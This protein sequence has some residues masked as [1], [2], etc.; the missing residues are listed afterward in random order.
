[1]NDATRRDATRRAAGGDAQAVQ[2]RD[3]AS[4]NKGALAGAAAEQARGGGP[5]GQAGRGGRRRLCGLPRRALRA[6]APRRGLGHVDRRAAPEPHARH[7]RAG[8]GAHAALPGRAGA[9]LSSVHN[10][11]FVLRRARRRYCWRT[12]PRTPRSRPCASPPAR[13]YAQSASRQRQRQRQRQQRRRG[14]RAR[15]TSG[16]AAPRIDRE[17]PGAVCR[18]RRPAARRPTRRPTCACC[19]RAPW[20]RR[21]A[22]VPCRAGPWPR[23]A[24][25]PSPAPP[26]SGRPATT[27]R[28]VG[29]SI[30]FA[31][32]STAMWRPRRR[33]SSSCTSRSSA[34]TR[35]RAGAR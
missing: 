31:S 11:L 29:D 35:S 32:S 30:V 19:A 26:S 22:L 21:A 7:G 28:P 8:H 24:T 10:S 23:S 4:L 33:A 2:F 15:A 6:F 18:R 17:W 12:T 20:A 14:G 9:R 13:R 3:E 27:A 34:R 25:A 1:M 5:G 16:A